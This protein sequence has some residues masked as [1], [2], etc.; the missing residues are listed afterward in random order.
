MLSLPSGRFKPVSLLQYPTGPDWPQPPSLGGSQIYSV[1]ATTGQKSHSHIDWGRRSAPKTGQALVKTAAGVFSLA[2]STCTHRRLN[3]LEADAYLE[4]VGG[5]RGWSVEIG[6]I[7]EPVVPSAMPQ[8]IPQQS[9]TGARA[10]VSICTE[11]CINLQALMQ[12]AARA[13][14]RTHACVAC[15]GSKTPS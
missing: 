14:A 1:K 6:P 10:T 15:E 3:M 8:L 7:A 2:S 13:Q 12:V 11:L 4:T 9:T 5:H